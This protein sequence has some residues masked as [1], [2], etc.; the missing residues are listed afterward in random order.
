[1]YTFIVSLSQPQRNKKIFKRIFKRYSDSNT[2]IHKTLEL[3]GN[4]GTIP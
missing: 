4:T 1:M 2:S 3:P